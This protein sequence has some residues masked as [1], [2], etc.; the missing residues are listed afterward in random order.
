MVSTGRKGRTSGFTLTGVAAAI[1]GFAVAL[2]GALLMVGAL[3]LGLLLGL[4]LISFA[5]LR[6]RRPQRVPFIW[7]KGEWPGR[8][9]S[10]PTS[11]GAGEFVDIEARVIPTDES[12]AR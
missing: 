8:T 4:G 12:K 9:R 5:L 7:R 6:G 2:F 3:L 11:A 1:V 10:V